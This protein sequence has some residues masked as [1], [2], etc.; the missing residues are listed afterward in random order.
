[1]S[2]EAVDNNVIEEPIK[3]TS[4]LK[5]IGSIAA[6]AGFYGIFVGGTIGSAYVSYRI[7]QMNLETAKLQLEAAAN[8]AQK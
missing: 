8:A 6:T 7:V 1:M 3:K 4:K 2:V 5:R